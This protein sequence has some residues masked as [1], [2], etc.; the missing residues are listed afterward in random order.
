[1]YQ[2][3]G[4]SNIF[5]CWKVWYTQL[6]KVKPCSGKSRDVFGNL[7]FVCS[8]IF[9]VNYFRRS[10]YLGKLFLTGTIFAANVERLVRNHVDMFHRLSYSEPLRKVQADVQYV[11][12][13]LM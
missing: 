2:P 3:F 11:N 4:K 6:S 9:Y 5:I 10:Q 7:A 12:I 8:Q 13:A 1:M